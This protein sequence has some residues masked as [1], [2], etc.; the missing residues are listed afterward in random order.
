MGFLVSVLIAPFFMVAFSTAVCASSENVSGEPVD[1]WANT[2]EDE[3]N[4]HSSVMS[5]RGNFMRNEGEDGGEGP[6]YNVSARLGPQVIAAGFSPSQIDISDT[7][8][9]IVAIARP[10]V[11]PIERVS[12]RESGEGSF[13]MAMTP[14]GV[15]FSGDEVY[16]ATLS[17]RRGA[18]GSQSLETI[19]GGRLGE[20]KIVATDSAQQHSHAFPDLRSGNYLPQMASTRE[21]EE[22]TYNQTA[23][24][25]PMVIMAG[26]SPSLLNL[27]DSSFDI[28][29]VVREG[30]FPV[31]KVS[32]RQ[33]GRAFSL[34]M[35]EAGQL[36]NGD[37]VF[38]ATYTYMRGA[39]GDAVIDSLW[40]GENGQYGI[41]VVDQAQQYSHHFPSIQ[42]GIFPT[43]TPGSSV[44]GILS[45]GQQMPPTAEFLFSPS[46][47][48]SPLTV[49]LNA[50]ASNDLDGV[51]HEYLWLIESGGEE[52]SR[53]YG[54]APSVE[55]I[56]PG[57]YAITLSVVDNDGLVGT[58]THRVT[59]TDNN[60]PPI[61]IFT[62]T[63]EA[64]AVPLSV[65]LDASLSRD[66]DGYI[67]SYR[68]SVQ[69]V[70]NS[71]WSS[72]DKWGIT[73]SV[74]LEY[75]GNYLVTL[76][77]TDN[78]GATK[79]I[80]QV[81]VATENLPTTT[82]LPTELRHDDGTSESA[83]CVWYST[84]FGYGDV[85]EYA[86]HFSVEY[87]FYSILS[88]KLYLWRGPLDAELD[89][90]IV[91]IYRDSSGQPGD[92][93]YSHAVDPIVPQIGRGWVDVD[94]SSAAIELSDRG[95]WVSMAWD[96][97]GSQGCDNK[98]LIGLDLSEPMGRSVMKDWAGQW[99]P[100][101]NADNIEVNVMI[102]SS[103]FQ[104][105]LAQE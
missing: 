83:T 39:L 92:I 44:S 103:V 104:R 15:F 27:G 41:V 43:V 48:V 68:W 45:N 28:V 102:R 19:W 3:F 17:F 57:I 38:K 66:L 36:S 89:P 80:G 18:F 34:V 2:K 81:I 59:V 98:P 49:S 33:N 23:R 75:A 65:N 63:P 12:F 97:S 21:Y 4:V 82:A 74:T 24:R 25:S 13:S 91:K 85:A 51:I 77:V 10:G 6:D 37:K 72:N 16:K 26:C 9:D 86:V 35:T 76:S 95:F 67:E 47:G 90:V 87:A 88:A 5:I 96:R 1:I 100:A 101:R 50:A 79:S 8:F 14:A 73:Q 71:E 55:L 52:V 84:D 64:G 60:I 53:A 11:I 61:P 69:D 32:L 56:S 31:D 54:V 93:L 30:M 20:F 22:V 94:L 70:D 58:V 99:V 46:E 42:F 62:A 7:E 105:E 29:A 78:D 40:G